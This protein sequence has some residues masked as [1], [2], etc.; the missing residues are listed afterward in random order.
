MT[1]INKSEYRDKVLA[2]WLGKNVGGTLGMPLEWKRQINNVSFYTQNLNGD[3]IP[4]DDL[5]IQLLWLV[6]LE[7]QG[8]DIDAHV[9]CEY[10]NIYLTPHWM[11]YGISKSNMRLG[12]PAP[13]CGI[14]NNNFKHS[15]G[16]FIRSEIW[17]CIAPGCPGLAV[18][19]AYEDAII[20]H[21]NGEGVYAE[22]FCAA[23][24]S[25]AFAVSGIRD[26]LDIGLSYIP[27]DCG[28]AKAVKAVI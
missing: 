12:M 1:R 2:C 17:A 26:L 23:V 25:A 6:A 13:L 21:G 19:Y 8:I 16:A 27:K 22:I 18:K 10:W 14:F 4:N 20:D 3:P 28:I 5:D 15:C 11:E 7:E 9:F 24:E